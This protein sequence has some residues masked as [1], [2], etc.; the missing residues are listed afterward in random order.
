[1]R[2]F[3]IILSLFL[4]TQNSFAENLISEDEVVAS[5]VKHY[6]VILSFYEKVNLAKGE[7]LKAKGFFDIKLRQNYYDNTRGFYDGKVSETTI[8]KELGFLNAKAYTSYRKSFDDFAVYDGAQVT[9]DR[10]EF[11]AGM[12][13]SLLRNSGIDENRLLLQVAELGVKDAE[14]QMKKIKMEIARDAKKAYW[15]AKTAAKIYEIYQNLYQLSLSRQSQ[16]EEKARKGAI[17]DIIVAENRKNILKRKSLLAKAKQDF[18]NKALFLSLFYRSENGEMKA[19]G[20]KNF[21]KVKFDLHKI[22]DEELKNDIDFALQAR[23]ELLALGV[24]KS[25]V[26]KELQYAQNLYKPQLDVEFGASK[27]SGKGSLSK[28]QSENF[29]NVDFSIPLQQREARGSE[30][31]ASA[32]LK[33]LQFEQQLM[34]DRVAIELKQNRVKIENIIEIYH[35]LTEET[36]LAEILE[37]AEREKFRS[38]ASNFFLVNMR[39]QDTA[40]AKAALLEIFAN[41]QESLADYGYAVFREKI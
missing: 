10:G 18:E 36:K 41:Y 17:A 24:E 14:I 38:G 29:V 6:P 21:S 22:G 1:M 3:G 25:V 33:S 5:G 35:N 27:D 16:L 34:Q 26:G 4:I 23:P 28:S 30:N 19:V 2:I 40:S 37:E 7:S 31:K 11:S 32:K 8:E 13:L 20:V 15:V 39:E 12:R 9:N